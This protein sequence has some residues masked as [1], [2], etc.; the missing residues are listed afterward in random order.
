[1][2]FISYAYME[3]C[4][5][6]GFMPQRQNISE[7]YWMDGNACYDHAQWSISSC[8]HQVCLGL[9]PNDENCKQMLKQDVYS[10]SKYSNAGPVLTVVLGF[11][12]LYNVTKE[13]SHIFYLNL[14]CSNTRTRIPWYYYNFSTLFLQFEN[15]TFCTLLLLIYFP[16]LS[17]MML[18]Q[19]F[20]SEI[21]AGQSC[22]L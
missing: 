16:F 5:N 15:I 19:P 14:T 18:F 10:T 1:M 4:L 6:P 13:W 11:V 20:P 8:L 7:F 22:F 21:S 2:A 3:I 9:H 12:V 17:S